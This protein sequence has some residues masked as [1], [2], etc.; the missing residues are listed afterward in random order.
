MQK[1]WIGLLVCVLVTGAI[2]TPGHAEGPPAGAENGWVIVQYATPAR[3]AMST[4]GYVPTLAEDGYRKL[5]V[6]AGKTPERY[7]AELR[8]QACDSLQAPEQ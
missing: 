2:S 7:A 8:A 4:T 5:R 1:R 6:P 3:A